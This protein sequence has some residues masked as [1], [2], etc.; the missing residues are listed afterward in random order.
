MAL[1][2]SDNTGKTAAPE[3]APIPGAAAAELA[4]DAHVRLVRRDLGGYRA[5]FERAA[6][7]E[8]ETERYRARRSLVEQGLAASASAPAPAVPQLYATVARCAVE[9]LETEPREP[10]LLNYLGVALYEIGAWSAAE[11]L[12]SAAQRLMPELPHVAGNLDQLRRRKSAGQAPPVVPAPVKA[13][14]AGL[15]K[16]GEACAAKA[17]PAAGLKL[18]LCM[19]VKDEEEML[20]AC[21]E[22]VA[23]A[24]DEIVIVDTGSTDRTVEIAESFGAQVIHHDWNG[25]FSDA[26]NVS[27]DAA[28]GDWFM[29]LDA[30]EVLIADDRDR[31]REL[32]GR[33]WREAFYLVET[34]HTGDMEDGTAVTHNALRVFRNRPAYRFEG[35]VHE[36]IAQHLPGDLPERFEPTQVRVEHYGYLGVVRD[37]KEKSRRNIELLERQ[38]ADGVDSPFLNFNLGSEHAAVGDAPAALRE[39]EQAWKALRGSADIHNRG[40]V[41]SLLNRLTKARRVTGNL[42]GAVRQAVE[43]LELFPGFTDLVYEQALVAKERGDADEARRLFEQCLEMGDAPSGY[44]PTV[45]CGSYM[46][47]VALAGLVEPGK[48]VELL[49]DC[50]ERFPAYLGAVLP[51]AEALVATGAGADEIVDSVESRV[52]AATPSVRFMLGTA[53]YEAGHVHHAEEQF[54]AVLARQPD[55]GPAQIALCECL[56]SQRRYAEAA[57][58]AGSV[59]ASAPLA[60]AAARTEI[61]ALLTAGDAAEAAEAL[62]RARRVGLP[63]AELGLLGAWCALAREEAPPRALPAAA[64]PALEAMLEA[65]LRVE[66][67]DAFAQLVP[68]VDVLELSWRERRE[69]LAQIYLRRGFVDSAADEWLAVCESGGPDADA[70]VGLAQVAL[71][72]GMGEDAQVFAEE[73]LVL[74]PHHPVAQAAARV[75]A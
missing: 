4:R 74:D 11:Q 30:D 64:A 3:R 43:G 56:L 63:G 61:F 10:L 5:L 29:Y 2:V 12:W 60:P 33:V 50:L 18:S 35:R 62:E 49:T 25:S 46:A 59:P 19:I 14:L 71:A 7:I 22:A 32:T 67:I 52:S 9:V 57:E 24:V 69:L 48:A 45:G 65:L 16:R 68:A 26:R 75:V 72:R 39:F 44:S 51:L 27:L 36:Q 73:A 55:S 31:L 17:Q 28:T 21:L 20:P 34:N 70:L 6:A 23:P 1:R 66:E 47:L 41:P 15:A 42:D 58:A 37:S 40:F 54:R 8:D 53:L 13:Q 38:L